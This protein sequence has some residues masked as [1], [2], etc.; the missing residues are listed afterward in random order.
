MNI[1]MDIA[2]VVIFDVKV[3]N[4]DLLE[5]QHMCTHRGVRGQK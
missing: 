2:G 3:F 4:E 1:N 5:F